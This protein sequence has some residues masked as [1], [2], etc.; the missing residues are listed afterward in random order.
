LNKNGKIEGTFCANFKKDVWLFLLKESREF[1]N[2]ELKK[3]GDMMI[4]TF[5]LDDVDYIINSHY[6]LYNREFNY[7]LSFRDFIAKSVEGFIRRSDNKENIWILEIDDKQN[8]SISIKKVN[9]DTAQL[10]LFLVEPNVRGTGYGQQLA[11][12]AIDFCKELGYKNII[13][14]TNSELKSARR[15]YKKNGFE[16]KKTQIQTLSNKELIEEQWELSI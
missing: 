11:Q 1:I 10:G 15:I 7:D 14:W 6:E 3:K 5:R 13:L 16:L 12:T 4:R 8:G 2:I 9:E